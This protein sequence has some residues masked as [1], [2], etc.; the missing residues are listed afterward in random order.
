M[1]KADLLNMAHLHIGQVNSGVANF[2]YKKLN[3]LCKTDL[4]FNDNAATKDL[5][6][7]MN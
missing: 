7:I 2:S 3:S 6:Y 4:L 5:Y 1:L